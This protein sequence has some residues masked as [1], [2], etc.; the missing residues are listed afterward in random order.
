MLTS[1]AAIMMAAISFSVYRKDRLNRLT[2]KQSV[3]Q[4]HKV[5]MLWGKMLLL[6][7]RMGPPQI[8]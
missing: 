5:R 6:N 3:A 8:C 7:E 4:I 1:S 2:N